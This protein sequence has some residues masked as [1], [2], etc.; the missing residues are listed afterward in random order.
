[1]TEGASIASMRSEVWRL[2]S[3]W[4]NV[5]RNAGLTVVALMAVGKASDFMCCCCYC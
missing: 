5:N 2:V 3:D 4:A 1:M